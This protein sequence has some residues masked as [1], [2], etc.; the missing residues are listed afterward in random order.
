MRSAFAVS[1]PGAAAEQSSPRRRRRGQRVGARAGV[2]AVLALAADELVLAGPAAQLVVLGA[3]VE[4]VVA[5]PAVEHGGCGR[6]VRRRSLPGAADDV[7][8]G[9]VDVVA[10]ARCAVVGLAVVGD[11]DRRGRAP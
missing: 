5:A 3:A 9:L 7:V 2:E 8:D 4:G 11:R 6:A 10:L 1:L